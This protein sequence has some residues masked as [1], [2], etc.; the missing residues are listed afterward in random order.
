LAKE[1]KT[2]IYSRTTY[3]DREKSGKQLHNF[4]I[5]ANFGRQ[6]LRLDLFFILANSGRQALR[7]IT[8]YISFSLAQNL[9]APDD[10]KDWTN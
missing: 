9:A 4:F 10:K 5:L 2:F 3:P 7:K 6:A 1:N 8:G